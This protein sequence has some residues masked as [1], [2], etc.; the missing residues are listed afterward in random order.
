MIN[1]E[2]DEDIKELFD[3]IKNRYQNNLESIK[4]S[5]F[6]FHYVQLFIIKNNSYENKT[7]SWRVLI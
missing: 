7:I 6:V 5:E 2:V 3:W 1:D 4:S